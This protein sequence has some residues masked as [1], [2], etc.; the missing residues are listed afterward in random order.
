[1][2]DRTEADVLDL[3]DLLPI[4]IHDVLSHQMLGGPLL[5]LHLILFDSLEVLAHGLRRHVLSG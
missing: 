2:E 4:A 1:M 5:I 3:S